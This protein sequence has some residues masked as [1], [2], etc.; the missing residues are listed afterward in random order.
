MDFNHVLV[1]TTA[2]GDYFEVVWK[3]NPP[4]KPNLWLLQIAPVLAES[5]RI[6]KTF[7]TNPQRTPLEDRKGELSVAFLTQ[8]VWFDSLGSLSDTQIQV[9]KKFRCLKSTES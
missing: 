1:F 4:N 5:L 3:K 8:K 2:S 9:L 6:V 7:E